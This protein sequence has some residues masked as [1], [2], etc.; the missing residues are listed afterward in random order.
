MQLALL[1]NKPASGPTAGY[2]SALPDVAAGIIWIGRTDRHATRRCRPSSGVDRESGWANAVE[3]MLSILESTGGAD[4][5][6]S[7][8]AADSPRAWR[9]SNTTMTGRI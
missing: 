5:P 2:V 9:V 6:V 4:A 1:C 8:L 3:A 7:L